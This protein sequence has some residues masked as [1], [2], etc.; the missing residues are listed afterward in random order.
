MPQYALSHQL[1]SLR[2]LCTARTVS[3]SG[4]QL[5]AQHAMDTTTLSGFLA[6][7][8]QILDMVYFVHPQRLAAYHVHNGSRIAVVM[9]HVFLD[10][11]IAG[12][13]ISKE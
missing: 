9:P 3:P 13:V 10:H 7:L 11:C 4:V 5:A 8:P 6:V 12:F 1:S 2:G